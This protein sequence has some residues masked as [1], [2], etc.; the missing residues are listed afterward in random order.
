MPVTG[1]YCGQSDIVPSLVE[2][3][4]MGALTSGEAG[5]PIVEAVLATW[6]ADAESEVDAYL[7]Q[8]YTLP[9]TGTV[10]QLV[11]RL[12]ARLA[13]FRAYTGRPGEVP[14]WLQ[15]DYDGAVKMLQSIAK[16]ELGIG[17]TPAGEAP[18]V[19]EASGRRVR[20]HSRKP[21][22]GRSNLEDY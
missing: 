20:T 15:K 11:T 16:G 13:R 19:D 12:S 17:L 21:V 14:E 6:V 4:V 18:A 22:F 8:R 1:R 7:C 10:P 3:S 9:I 5:E 2:E